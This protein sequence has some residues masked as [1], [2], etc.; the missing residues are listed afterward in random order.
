MPLAKGVF[1]VKVRFGSAL[2]VSDTGLLLRTEVNPF[3]GGLTRFDVVCFL[4][5]TSFLLKSCFKLVLLAVLTLEFAKELL[6]GSWCVE[7]TFCPFCLWEPPR[8][9]D[10]KTYW[11]REELAPGLD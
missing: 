8:G 2:A 4:N 6:L 5:P 10:V 3:I 1:I 11:L 9:F 7:G